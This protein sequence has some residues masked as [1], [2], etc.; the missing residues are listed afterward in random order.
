[1]AWVS[2]NDT[3]EPQSMDVKARRVSPEG[4][5]LD[6][7]AIVVLSWP[8]VDGEETLALAGNGAGSVFALWQ[9]GQGEENT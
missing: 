6:P 8:A 3:T 1:M 2:L 5:V 7:A 4:V 9:L